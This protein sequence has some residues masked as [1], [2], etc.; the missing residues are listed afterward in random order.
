MRT[1]VHTTPFPAQRGNGSPLA[2]N[3]AEFEASSEVDSDPPDGTQEPGAPRKR[4]SPAAQSQP[5]IG[6]ERRCTDNS[7]Q[8]RSA[9]MPLGE[10]S[11]PRRHLFACK[12]RISRQGDI[13]WRRLLQLPLV[14]ENNAI[15]RR[16]RS[17]AEAV[18]VDEKFH[19]NLGVVVIPLEAGAHAAR[20][21]MAR[22]NIDF[23]RH[24]GVQRTQWEQD[25]PAFIDSHSQVLPACRGVRHI[26]P[27]G[28]RR[29]ASFP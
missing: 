25:A 15:R 12:H 19:T 6:L 22:G 10:N 9:A 3:D 20:R 5:V 18:L 26:P 2:G 23:S 21:K 17:R 1:R 7:I 4:A 28:Q 11:S 27:R 13:L 14:M 24:P 16:N 29:K 8:N